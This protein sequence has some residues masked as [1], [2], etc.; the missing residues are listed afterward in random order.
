VPALRRAVQAFLADEVAPDVALRRL[1]LVSV[2]AVDLLDDGA[3]E[4]L[5]TDWIDRARR[6]G[7]LAVLADGLAFRSA[8]VDAPAA[9]ATPV[10]ERGVADAASNFDGMAHAG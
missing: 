8:F 2:A 5:A 4:Q 1:E 9:G 10:I 6:R 3:L 7:A